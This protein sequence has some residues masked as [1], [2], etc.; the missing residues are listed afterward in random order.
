MTDA[1]CAR[2]GPTG[3]MI[4]LIGRLALAE[5]AGLAGRQSPFS[6]FGHTTL[7]F[8]SAILCRNAE[9]VCPQ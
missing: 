4:F 6:Q 8:W 3:Q 2:S 9:N 7:A 1:S 5:S